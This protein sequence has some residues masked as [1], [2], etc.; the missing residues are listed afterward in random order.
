M[1]RSK[2]LFKM[3]RNTYCRSHIQHIMRIRVKWGIFYSYY[4]R[5]RSKPIM[6]I[7]LQSYA[8]FWLFR[9]VSIWDEHSTSIKSI[10]ILSNTRIYICYI[11]HKNSQYFRTVCNCAVLLQ[12]VV[13]LSISPS[14]CNVEVPWSWSP[15]TSKIITRVISLLSSLLEATST[16]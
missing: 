3:V 11:L 6:L 16:I 9:N 5:L 8:K 10:I 4:C 15:V 2:H 7:M 14:V 1:D 13:R 12:K